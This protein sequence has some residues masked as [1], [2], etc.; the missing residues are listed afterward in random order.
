MHDFSSVD[1]TLIEEQDQILVP[2]TEGEKVFDNVIDHCQGTNL[3]VRSAFQIARARIRP[4]IKNLD[5]LMEKVAWLLS[6][7]APVKCA[8][9]IL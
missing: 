9:L 1:K 5:R 7:V 3:F 8:L 6:H 4:W 2:F